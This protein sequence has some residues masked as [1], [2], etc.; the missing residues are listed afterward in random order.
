[1]ASSGIDE[2]ANVVA[3]HLATDEPSDDP[4][5]LAAAIDVLKGREGD[6]E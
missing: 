5:I 6:D 1:M 4:E 3:F 2:P